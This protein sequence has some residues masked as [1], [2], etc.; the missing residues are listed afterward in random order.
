[1]KGAGGISRGR[2]ERERVWGERRGHLW[3]ELETQTNGNP[4]E[5][6]WV[7][8]AKTPSHLLQPEKTFSGGTGMP[9]RPQNLRAKICLTY[10]IYR[11]KDGTEI[12]GM[13]S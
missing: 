5:S 3:D 6:L 7:T 2:L 11:G 1:M 13:T 8:I 10:K 9:S 4:Q 12:E